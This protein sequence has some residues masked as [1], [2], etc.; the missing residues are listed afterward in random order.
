MV[1]KDKRIAVRDVVAGPRLDAEGVRDGWDATTDDAL[2]SR[3][4]Y[5]ADM[6]F[7]VPV[8]A[9]RDAS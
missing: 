3:M 4:F 1:W 5:P 6:F 8:E 2:A 7:F 9:A